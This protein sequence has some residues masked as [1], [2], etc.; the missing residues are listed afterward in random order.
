MPGPGRGRAPAFFLS[1]LCP[2]PP[3]LMATVVTFRWS[4]FASTAGLLLQL[5]L[6]TY[7][8]AKHELGHACARLE[9][10]IGAYT[11][12]TSQYDL[13]IKL[14]LSVPHLVLSRTKCHRT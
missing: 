1:S 10:Y 12:N 7:F 3:F 5:R 13:W 2:P 14:R 9:G 8:T 11:R 4:C 6:T